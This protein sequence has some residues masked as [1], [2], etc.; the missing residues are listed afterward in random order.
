MLCSPGSDGE[1]DVDRVAAGEGA[2]GS[3]LY[4]TEDGKHIA[5][6]LLRLGICPQYL[7]RYGPK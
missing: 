4:Q 1:T 5:I 6:S 7:L 2:E 3:A